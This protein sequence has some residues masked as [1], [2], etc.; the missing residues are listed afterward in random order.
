[1]AQFNVNDIY[2]WVNTLAMQYQSG[3]WSDDQFNL[4]LKFVNIELLRSESGMPEAYQVGNPQPPVAWQVTNT[5]SDDLRPFVIPVII[6]KDA[7]GYFPFPTDYA[8]FS[9]MWYRYKIN[10]TT[11]K[12]EPTAKD[13]YIEPVS[14]DE[15]RT[16]L[17]S[18][19][20]KPDFRYPIF[21]WYAYGYQVYPETLKQIE[22]TYLKLPRTPVWG[23]TTLA[24]GQTQYDPNTSVQTE[25]PDTLIPSFTYRVCK[26]L[27]ITIREDQFLSYIQNRIE[28]G[29]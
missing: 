20:K 8:A 17:N 19:I 5:I 2:Q 11:C 22:L 12:A 14:D 29:K 10:P 1:M 26:Y 28:T 16:R 3:E 9:S 21:T 13:T 25:Y 24:N 7:N 4:A 23:Y 15:L 18:N 27:G 6:N